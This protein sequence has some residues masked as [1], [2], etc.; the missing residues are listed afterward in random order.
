MGSKHI[1][2]FLRYLPIGGI[3]KVMVR[4]ANEFAGRNHIVD[5]V[6]AKEKGVLASEVASNVRI[7][8]L[9]KPRVW[10]ALPALLRYLKRENP[11][12]LLAAEAPV[13]IVAIW[14]KLFSLKPLRVIIS[15]H[16][17]MSRYVRSAEIWYGSCLYFMIKYFYPYA[18]K[19]VA[20]SEGVLDD[21][22]TVSRRSTEKSCVIYNPVSEN[23]ILQK[24]EYSVVHPWLVDKK[25]PVVLGV[26]RLTKQKNFDLL[27]RAFSRVQ[28]VRDA[29]L[30]ILGEGNQRKYLETQIKNLAIEDRVDLHGFVENP[31]PYMANASLLVVSSRFEG[32]GIVIVEA[33]ACGCPVVSTD[34]PSGPREIL[35]DGKW[36]RLAPVGEEEALAE[37]ME[38][39]LS[40]THDPDRLRQRAM[41]FSVD[42][43]VEKYLR[44]LF[45]RG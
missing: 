17:N 21:L 20:V 2:L 31:Y 30:I 10:M 45:S 8:N 35:E 22:S 14:A 23:D 40:E 44:I 37:A 7:V 1:A 34:C 19:I 9:D 32:F 12:V 38:K 16:N 25:A 36:G 43:A 18:D 15:V 26:G 39:S 13:N 29:R 24:A 3:Q 5:L 28:Q 33:L 41:D 4:L 11:D 42:K 27:L 6:V